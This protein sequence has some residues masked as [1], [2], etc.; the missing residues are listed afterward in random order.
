[1]KTML[2]A[3]KAAKTEITRLTPDQKNAALTDRCSRKRNAS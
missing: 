3:A 1:M 2:E